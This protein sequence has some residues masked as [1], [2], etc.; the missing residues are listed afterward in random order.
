V[1]CPYCRTQWQNAIDSS[2]LKGLARTGPKNQDG[3]VN[4]AN[5]VGMYAKRD[6]STYHVSHNAV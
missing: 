2:S 6:Y 1:T 5:Q 3:Y 4:V